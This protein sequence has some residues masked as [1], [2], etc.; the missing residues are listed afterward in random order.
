MGGF[1][2]GDAALAATLLIV[3]TAAIRG[4]WS[5]CGLSMISAINPFSERARGHRFWLT[6]VWFILGSVLGGAG[7]GALGAVGAL[8]IEAISLPV[9][10]GFALAAC[11][12]LVTAAS[13]T[14]MFGFRLPIHPRQVNEHWLARYR[15]WV[16]AAGFGAQIGTGLATYIMTA[17]VYLVP[18]LGALSGSPSIALLLGVLFGLVRGLGV[19]VSV[20]TSTPEGLRRLHRRLDRLGPVSLGAAVLVQCCAAIVFGASAGGVVGLISV[21]LVLLVLAAGSRRKAA[22]PTPNPAAGR[23]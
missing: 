18:I 4:I 16:Y 3:V 22:Q 23:S 20:T 9:A 5:P 13:D 7:L 10:V 1:P 15:R 2:G 14:T 11:C 6:A 17:A 12:A 8:M 21:L 19:L